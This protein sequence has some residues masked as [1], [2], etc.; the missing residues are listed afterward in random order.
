MITQDVRDGWRLLVRKPGFTAIAVLTLGVGIGANITIFSLTNAV[1][2]RPLAI[3]RSPSRGRP[4]RRRSAT[5][6]AVTRFL[7]LVSRLHPTS[8]SDRRC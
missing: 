7:V 6:R 3:V 1:L 2:L 4:A 8:G 5:G